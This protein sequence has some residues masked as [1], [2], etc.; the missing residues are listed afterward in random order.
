MYFMMLVPFSQLLLLLLS[1]LSMVDATTM[2]SKPTSS[3][4]STNR[5]LE[6][7]NAAEDDAVAAA[8]A[9][10]D[11]VVE[12]DNEMVY[13]G[14]I[15]PTNCLSYTI[16]IDNDGNDDAGANAGGTVLTVGQESFVFFEYYVDGQEAN[17]EA[18]DLILAKTWFSATTGVESACIPIQN[19]STVFSSAVLQNVIVPNGWESSLYFGPLC[20]SGAGAYMTWGVFADANCYHYVPG[21]TY[22]LGVHHQWNDATM[23][24]LAQQ[25]NIHNRASSTYID[26]QDNEYDACTTILQQSV[27]LDNCM[28]VSEEVDN[29]DNQ[30]GNDGLNY[31]DA[32]YN[33]AYDEDGYYHMSTQD[34]QGGDGDWTDMCYGLLISQSK[35]QTLNQWHGLY[36]NQLEQELRSVYQ[37]ND[38]QMFWTVNR[39]KILSSMGAV[40]FLLAVSIL[41]LLTIRFKNR[42]AAAAANVD[43]G[44]VSKRG[45]R[46]QRRQRQRV[47]TE[48]EKNEALLTKEAATPSITMTDTTTIQH[49]ADYPA[50]QHDEMAPTTPAATTTTA[51]A[52]QQSKRRFPWTKDS[53]DH[54]NNNNNNNQRRFLWGNNTKKQDMEDVIGVDDDANNHAATSNSVPKA[55]DSVHV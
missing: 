43:D 19:P 47:S 26:C 51:T 53:T 20:D 34:L 54:N 23:S 29:A 11:A 44:M 5:L 48:Y 1:S 24:T 40:L 28:V 35:G 33:G 46:R 30:D 9:E 55:Q 36:H 2:I 32:N 21:L 17:S 6:E 10:N 3:M 52:A 25:L 13:T 41:V 14:S 7:M 42:R 12:E 37:Y 39:T 49:P 31:D 50:D 18:G 8:E 27:D 45:Q 4:R 16:L 22:W 15:E 38:A